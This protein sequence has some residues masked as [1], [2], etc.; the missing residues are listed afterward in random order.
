MDRGSVRPNALAKLLRSLVMLTLSFACTQHVFRLLVESL[1]HFE[2]RD[3]GISIDSDKEEILEALKELSEKFSKLDDVVNHPKDGIGAKLVNLTLRGD[4]FHTTVH[5]AADG[6][7][8]NMSKMKEDVQNQA[9]SLE[10]LQQNQDRLSKMLSE[11]KRLSTDLLTAQGLIQ[12]Y[13]QKIKALEAKVL[14][15]TRRGMEQNVIIHGIEER[16]KPKEEDCYRTVLNFISTWFPF[17]IDEGEIWKAYRL[18][19]LKTNRARPMF[20]KFSY[21]AKE[22]IMQNVS[23]LKGK[24]NVHN[25]VL[26]ISEQIPEGITESRKSL[27]KRAGVLQSIENKKPDK[28]RREVKILGEHVIVGGE[29]DKQ[30]IMTPQPFELFPGS[31]EQAEINAINQKIKEAQPGFARNSTFVGLALKVKS[32]EET[33]KA[34]KAVMQRFPF[35]DHV[36]LAYRFRED[37]NIK[38]G[39]CDDGE[40]GGG[41]V[42]SKLL[43]EQRCKNIAVFVVR[44]YGGIHMGFDRFKEITV[45]A[46]KAVDLLDPEKG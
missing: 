20:V 5:G 14:D 12:K 40:H 39:H 4:N 27:T 11:N 8:V 2:K 37:Q 13:S 28:E 26:F 36:M 18:G 23:A 10:V 45:A 38:I 33:N 3:K 15:L 46:Q 9:K 35:M 29:V 16:G 32:A 30:E 41:A 44:R 19:V 6:L 21:F 22:K 24:T 34:Y 17:E 43:H 42:I 25:Q 31:Q 7:M 1:K